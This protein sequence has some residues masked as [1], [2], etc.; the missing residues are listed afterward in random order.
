VS[1]EELPS[2]PADLARTLREAAD[3][4]MGGWTAALNSPFG[5]DTGAARTAAGDAEPAGTQDVAGPDGSGRA[6]RQGG[7]AGPGGAAEPGE[8]DA[9]ARAGSGTGRA[10]GAGWPAV[11]GMPDL[12]ALLGPLVPPAT[13]SARQLQAV[14][15][16]LAARRAQVQ[17]LRTQLGL[18]DEQLAA[19]ETSLGPV[20]EWTKAWAGMEQTM[21]NLWRPPPP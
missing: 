18:F 1:G 19:L 2:T 8:R 21:T 6:G 5:S 14:L 3:R 11:P 9:K 15:D 17:A 13:L 12:S 7:A 4:L 16:D 20:L 10:S